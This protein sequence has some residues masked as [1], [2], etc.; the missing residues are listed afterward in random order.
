MALKDPFKILLLRH[1]AAFL[2]GSKSFTTSV[3]TS[4]LVLTLMLAVGVV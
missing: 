2:F 4:C 3:F 1:I